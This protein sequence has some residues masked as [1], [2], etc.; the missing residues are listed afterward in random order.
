MKSTIWHFRVPLAFFA[1]T[2]AIDSFPL[3][4][5]DLPSVKTA[6]PGLDQLLPHIPVVPPAESL[7]HFRVEPGFR[8][9]LAEAE[10]DVADPVDV[11]FD[12]IGRMYVC[13]LWNY[14]G[15]PKAGEPLGRIRLLTSSHNDGV[16]DRSAIFAENLRWPSG[17]I[18]WDGGVYVISSPDIWYL[19]D[20]KGV[21]KADEFKK[22]FTGLNGRTY[23]IGNSLRWGPD[24]RIYVCGSYA[25]G[26]LRKVDS[27]EAGQR[28]RDFRFDPRTNV[29][30]PVSG[31]GEWGM[32][33]NDWGDR[34]N[35]DAT[36]LAHHAVLPREDLA[37]N[38]FLAVPSV[39][40]RCI[41][42][43]TPVFPISRPEPWKAVRQN[44]WKKWVNSNQDMNAGRFPETELSPQG[45]ATSAC[46]L[47][48]YRGSVFP[49]EYLEDGFI[50]EPANNVVVRLRFREQAGP[51]VTASRAPGN[52]TREF[53]ASTDNRFRP[54]NFANGPDGCLY[55]ISMYREIIEDE[56]AIPN[57]ILKHYD[58]YSGRDLGRIYRIMPTDFKRRPLPKLAG[59]T[60]T[61]LVAL[62]GHGDSW[63]RE[64]A[65]R[66][67]YQKQDR[68]AAESLR[69]FVAE[70]PTAQ[71][72]IHALWTLR[73]IGELDEPSVLR[74]AGDAEPHV[75]EQAVILAGPLLKQSTALQEMVTALADDP[76]GRVRFRVA[77]AALDL[78]DQ[79]AIRTLITIARRD[80][81]D[82]WA[83]T[84]I[85]SAVPQQA[86]T[87]AAA[88]VFDAEFLKRDSAQVL[89]GLLAQ[90][91]GARHDTMEVATILRVVTGA[92][93]EAHS[94]W[95]VALLR[96]LADG[97]NRG[98]SSLTEQL[99]KLESTSNEMKGRLDG[100][101]GAALKTA[102]DATK[103]ER[104]RIEAVQLLG[105]AP[106][107]TVSTTLDALLDPKQAPPVQLAAVRALS[108]HGEPEVAQTLL[109]RW[110]TLG[111]SVRPDVIEAL[112]RR[113]GR[114]PALLDA[115]QA[116]K[117]PVAELVPSQR[118]R[119]LKNADP[120]IRARAEKLLVAEVSA[121]KQ[122]L[123][124]R[125][126]SEVLKLAGDLERGCIVFQNNCAICHRPEQGQPPGPNL[127]TLE[128]RS[129]QTLLVAILDPNREV[130]PTYVNFVLTTQDQQ[131]FSGVVVNESAN[132]VTIRRAG[133]GED[134]VLRGNIATLRSTGLSLMPDGLDAAISY[135]QM[136]DL[137][138]FLQTLKD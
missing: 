36:H 48:V 133:G 114:L 111:P 22:I 2:I 72:K 129:P 24:N 16:Y 87:L 11:A 116:K 61:E 26:N 25:G 117:F 66:L 29:V 8:I 70:S 63:V 102:A 108:A 55:V 23:E 69:Q 126:K 125:Y 88:L 5:Q 135:Q 76:S 47:T 20:T 64:T 121:D 134:T 74:A 136:A 59:A 115:I 95:R 105:Y 37:R 101:F 45:F 83:R 32:T 7:K 67:L 43:W 21:G 104:E 110:R 31:A 58:L 39:V 42:E 97:L 56:T 6:P 9:E 50:G 123:I 54:V 35:C 49:A 51:S 77:F 91:G 132:S 92:S 12:E 107:A 106:L 84:A 131:D 109:A 80:A 41:G 130:K 94:D 14:P 68:G 124:D 90:S 85:A 33:F 103:L 86:G 98:G 82:V 81:D 138:R 53:L 44:F 93:L 128:D 137:L 73:G 120:A 38:Q 100:F 99:S 28:S 75:R 62:L 17:I 112:F 122:Q 52:E 18:C 118:N 89:L 15:V 1:A 71:G 60:T 78:P 4:A 19:K 127:A 65:Q 34:F 27:K 57:D 10:P 96:Q 79:I 30:Q 46:G 113:G 13:E 40:E 3:F 119:L